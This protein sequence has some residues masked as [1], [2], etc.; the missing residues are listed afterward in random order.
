MEG[1]VLSRPKSLWYFKIYLFQSGEERYK[2]KSLEFYW[3]AEATS[4]V[5][6]ILVRTGPESPLGREWTAEWKFLQQKP[7][8]TTDYNWTQTILVASR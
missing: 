8:Y 7:D 2:C 6:C 5:D 1:S 4:D 3:E